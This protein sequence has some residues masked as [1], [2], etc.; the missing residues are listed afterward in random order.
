VAQSARWE[1]S[2]LNHVVSGDVGYGDVGV[3]ESDDSCIP[4]TTL[5]A[6]SSRAISLSG[7]GSP[8]GHLPIGGF[9]VRIWRSRSA[10]CAWLSASRCTYQCRAPERAWL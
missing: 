4:P 2:C 6:C 7:A 1:R 5:V 9:Q 3:D 8:W 10:W